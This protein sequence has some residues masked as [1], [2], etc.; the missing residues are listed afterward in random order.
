[1]PRAHQAGLRGHSVAGGLSESVRCHGPVLVLL[2]NGGVQKQQ[3]NKIRD[4]RNVLAEKF[5]IP[6]NQQRLF[7]RGKQLEDGHNLFDY[8]VGL[9][10][11]V[12]MLIKEVDLDLVKTS[13]SPK[14]LAEK[15]NKER[16]V[17]DW[18]SY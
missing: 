6:T 10:D 13:P 7:Y 15:V 11:I 2:T 4:L 1:M 3:H 12:Q 14:P 5:K 16:K 18:G 17:I 9:N 8:S